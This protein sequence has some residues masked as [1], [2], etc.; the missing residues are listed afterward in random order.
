MTPKT[1]KYIINNLKWP[2]GSLDYCGKYFILF[3]PFI[4]IYAGLGK[5]TDGNI[6]LSLI[7][8]GVISFIYIVYRIESERKF[9]ELVFKNDLST[10]EIAK[11][12]EKSGWILTNWSDGVVRL[13][14]NNSLDANQTITI[15][16]VT[17]EK[18]LINTQPN[19]RPP[20][21][22]FKDVMNY[23]QVKKVL[24]K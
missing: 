15:I 4:L 7:G 22:F 8:A 18:I 2:A 20:F 3:F 16:K 5:P 9:K 1:R 11:L 23:N 21:T 10:I 6:E 14:T 17:K 13:R 12:L 19:G 24:T